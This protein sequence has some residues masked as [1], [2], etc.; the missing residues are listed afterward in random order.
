MEENKRKVKMA[1]QFTEAENPHWRKTF[2]PI[3]IGQ[4]LSLIGSR[5]VGFALIWYITESTGSAIVLTTLALVGHLPEMVLGPFAGALVDRWNRQK[6]MIIADG[7]IA[8]LTLVIALLFA[9]D[10]I[11][12]WHIYVLM[13]GR[14]IGGAF[15]YTAMGASTSL[16]VPKERF[17]KIQGI[18]QLLQG[19]L[20]IVA[21]PLGAL[22]IELM[23]IGN[24]MF[25]DVISAAIAIA[26]LFFVVIPQ[27]E[28]VTTEEQRAN[29]VK[30]MF[31]DVGEGF[32]YL[33]KWKGLFYVM[34]LATGIN[35]IINPAFTLLPLLVSDTFGLGA[36]A[37]ATIQTTLGIATIIGSLILSVWGGFKRKVYTSASA[38]GVSTIGLLLMAIAPVNAF[39]MLV[40]G[41]AIFAL[42][43]PIVNGPFM[44][45]FQDTVDPNMQGRVFA[46]IGTMAGAA[47]P[48]GL[49]IAG[50]VSEYFGVQSWF[51]VGAIY[52][53][54]MTAVL[55]LVPAIRNLEDHHKTEL[56]PV[57]IETHS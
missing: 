11:Q 28:V 53:I 49:M 5:M 22:A 40:V 44:A 43:N 31:S 30:T 24:I 8:F 34:L 3:W 15:H 38:L 12:L 23:E 47:S 33:V 7:A 26:P 52:T 16:M 51:M 27:P 50:P 32:R 45:I 55:F 19:F 37:L 13:F 29:P 54:F 25:I 2:F 20:A 57:M 4:A 18:N 36:G 14:S 39:W 48:I 9:L 46:L 42:L 6:V 41:I 1:T 56:A 10:L 21:A 35:A 17:T